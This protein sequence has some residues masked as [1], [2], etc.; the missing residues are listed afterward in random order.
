MSNFFGFASNVGRKSIL[1]QYGIKVNKTTQSDYVINNELSYLLD[2]FIKKYDT[3][4]IKN[5]NI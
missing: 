5:I 2:R 1:E 4:S 3:L